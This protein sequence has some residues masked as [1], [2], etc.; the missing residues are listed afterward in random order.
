MNAPDELPDWIFG[1]GSLIWRPDFA[2]EAQMTAHLDGWARGF[3]QA[4]TDHRGVP[5]AP[6]RVATLARAPFAIT[7]GRAF[8][9][10][11]AERTRILVALDVREQGGYERVVA[12]VRLS[13]GATVDALFY[14]ATPDNPN[15]LGP[16][17]LDEIAAQIVRSRGPSGPND[18]YLLELDLALREMGCADPHVAALAGL[19]RG[20]QGG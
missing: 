8:R 17:P 12:P 13:D 2:F 5:G 1:Y 11:A 19:V 6:G 15:H 9:I 10:S 18:E 16:A 7:C 3:W 14:V 4:S 20:L